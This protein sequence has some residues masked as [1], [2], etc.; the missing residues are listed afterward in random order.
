MMSLALDNP[1]PIAPTGAVATAIGWVMIVVFW[2]CM[3]AV[4]VMSGHVAATVRG[5]GMAAAT[6][7]RRRAVPASIAALVLIVGLVVFSLLLPLPIPFAVVMLVGT[8][9]VASVGVYVARP[10]LQKSSNR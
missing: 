2:V 7:V 6:E 10:G 1:T 8:G 5:E 9:I 3:A 4:G